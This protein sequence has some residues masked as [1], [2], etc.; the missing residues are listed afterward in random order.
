M[1][2]LASSIGLW[3]PAPRACTRL[4]RTCEQ[5]IVSASETISV[6]RDKLRISPW[7]GSTDTATMVPVS[8]GAPISPETITHG[9]DTLR[10]RGF[11]HIV[12]S[13]LGPR[14]SRPFE[15]VGF[16]LH[17]ELHLLV[18][19]L[20]QNPVST[21]LNRQLTRSARRGDWEQVLAIDRL[22]FDEFWQFDGA[23]IRDAL[24]ATPST[25]FHVARA[26]PPLGYHI[27]GRAGQ[28]GYLQRLAVHPDAHR[29]GL[30]RSLLN[31]SLAWLQRRNVRRVFVNTQL[32]NTAA[33]G[34]YRAE[35]FELESYRLAV[36]QL[37][38]TDR[39]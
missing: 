28:N 19:D 14:E 10:H 38:L 15:L 31:D 33:Y 24:R 20:Q 17:H 37:Q 16:G 26:T 3:F 2:L 36:L 21:R 35:A 30:G 23:A 34:L 8:D 13:A 18:R 32:E 27:T 25:R 22:A 39:P 9:V 29:Q 12:T 6:G 1:L 4:A 5:A 7:R 11:R